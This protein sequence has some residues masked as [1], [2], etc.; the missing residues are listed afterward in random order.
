LSFLRRLKTWP[1]FGP[2]SARRVAE[3][4]AFS[5]AL[6]AKGHG[7]PAQ[8]TARANGKAIVPVNSAAQKGTA[9]GALAAGTAAAGQAA[10]S[11]ARPAVIITILAVTVALTLVAWFFW[12]R[13]QRR[14]QVA[15]V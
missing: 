7:L 3:V 4:R 11:G 2:G 5:L 6:A 14:Q 8:P 9:C 15:A 13:R 10:Q 1:V 12:R